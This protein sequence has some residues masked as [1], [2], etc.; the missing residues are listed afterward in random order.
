MQTQEL[1]AAIADQFSG[2]GIA[3]KSVGASSLTLGLPVEVADV[4]QVFELA[5]DF[6]AAVDFKSTPDGPVLVV[7]PEPSA[8]RTQPKH[9]NCGVFALV[10]SVLVLVATNA[11]LLLFR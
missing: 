7:Y 1:S 10:A 3:V 8:E 4:D 2:E 6:G 5:S 9:A 11:W